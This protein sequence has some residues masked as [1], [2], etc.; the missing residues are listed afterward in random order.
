MAVRRPVRR[1][2]VATLVTVLG[3]V[4]SVALSLPAVLAPLGVVP[5]FGV[6]LVLSE[7]GFAVAAVAFLLA[8]GRSFDYV[9]WAGVDREV[10]RWVAGGTAGLFALRVAAIGVVQALGL[11]VAES[12][13]TDLAGQGYV[14]T[15]LLLVPLS[16]LVVGPAEELLF[17]GVVQR[18]LS[19]CFSTTG[20]V[21]GA[22]V[23]FALVHL[24]TTLLAVADPVVTDADLLAVAVTLSIVFAL[25]LG[26][27]YLYA[28]TANLAVPVFVHGCYDALLFALAY[29][30]AV[31]PGPA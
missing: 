7:L 13:V 15:L 18:Y 5:R 17:R 23:L 12:S 3:V 26:L 8:T 28:R 16:V 1:T 31:G 27:G 2:V 22:S 19:G 25:S 24:P 29:V 10:V 4:C 21:V 30:V 14:A 11:P 9:R 6:L 20:A